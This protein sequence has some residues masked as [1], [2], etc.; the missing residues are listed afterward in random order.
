MS[1]GQSKNSP[2]TPLFGNAVAAVGLA[3]ANAS[4]LPGTHVG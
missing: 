4:K 1:S 2:Q 3:E